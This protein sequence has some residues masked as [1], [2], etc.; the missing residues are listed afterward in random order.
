MS[1]KIVVQ[2]SAAVSA[3]AVH[4]KAVLYSSK[5]MRVPFLLWGM[6]DSTYSLTLFNRATSA[7]LETDQALEKTVE[8]PM[9]WEI[10]YSACCSSNSRV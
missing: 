2:Y 1:S 7:H 4:S 9:D 3:C 10:N 8:G 6:L 5:L